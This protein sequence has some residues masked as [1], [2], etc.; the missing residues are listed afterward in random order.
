MERAPKTWES[1]EEVARHLIGACLEAFGLSAMEGKQS[2]PG[3]ISGTDWEIEGKGVR[4]G[5]GE[6]VILECRRY[7]GRRLS[8]EALGGLAWRIHDT[9]AAGGIVV[10][11]LELQEGA[12][13]IAAVAEVIPVRLTPDSTTTEYVMSFLDQVRLGFA[14]TA[15]ADMFDQLTIKVFENGTLIR[16]EEISD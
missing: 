16:T 7:P 11:P 14:D 10:S 15:S 5:E 1:Y 12:A 8:Q 4:T 9:G 3:R 13:K 6:F 2:V